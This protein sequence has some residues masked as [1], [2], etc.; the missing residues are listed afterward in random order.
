MLVFGGFFQ[1]C[2]IKDQRRNSIRSKR[3]IM[4]ERGT[5]AAIAT[6]PGESGI[7]IIRVSGPDAFY[8]C[9]RML[10][11]KISDKPTHTIHYCHVKDG[12]RI[13]DEV[14]VTLMR[15]PR[16][17]TGEDTAEINCHGNTFLMER[18]LEVC[19]RCGA[20]PA[21][22]GEFTKRAFLNGRIDLSQAE[23]VMDL[24]RAQSDSAS[25]AAISQLSGKLSGKVREIRDSLVD[26][27]AEIEAA[28]DDPEHYT[29]EGFTEELIK[30]VDKAE[31]EIEALIRSADS[32]RF[33][34]EGI[35]TVILGK[36]NAGKSSLLNLF[37]GQDRAIVTNIPGTT[38]DTLTEHIRL[39]RYL[40]NLTDTA[41]IRES[42]DQ[43]ERI[44][45]ERA[46][47][48]AEEA[49]LLL[50]L[51]DGNTGLTEEDMELL[52]Y[53]EQK[54][55]L[56]LINKTDLPSAVSK[57]ELEQRTSHPV[58]QISALTGEG[59]EELKSTIEHMFFTGVVGRNESAVITNLRHKDALRRAEES[60]KLVMDSAEAGMPE[61]FL[62][63]DLCDAC[64]ALGEITGETASEDIIDRVFAKF[65]MGK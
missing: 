27:T 42:S 29:L 19:L 5:I 51:V 49:D 32:G 56:V 34:R 3:N 60:L 18:V 24:I 8:V 26:K 6:P 9:D 53:A 33:L 59:F 14:L 46:R 38:R 10:D 13:L 20:V 40:L 57:E 21:E 41:G 44:G 17:Y 25:D 4:A 47:K 58:I 15:T 62:S 55:A 39:G 36:P 45:I 63:I 16:S 23:A 52:Q 22:P 7:G 2:S 61:D 50:V 54:K 65:C 35:S 11:R 31:Q 28:L 12:E 30:C 48:S 37:S 1:T 43:V 64:T